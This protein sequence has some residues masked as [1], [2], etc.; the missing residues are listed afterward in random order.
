MDTGRT[1]ERRRQPASVV[2]STAS[3]SPSRMACDEAGVVEHGLVGV[4]RGEAADGL[5]NVVV[6]PR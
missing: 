1:T 4:R 5:S 6:D 2:S 3:T